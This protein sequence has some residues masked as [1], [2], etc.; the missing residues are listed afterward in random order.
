[1]DALRHFSS[2]PNKNISRRY[3]LHA[4]ATASRAARSAVPPEIIS[5]PPSRVID[6]LL[7]AFSFTRARQIITAWS[8]S[9][10]SDAVYYLSELWVF[11]HRNR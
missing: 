7:Y 6:G 8:A 5:G 9:P 3:G 11:I 4:A 2:R 1:M 10:I